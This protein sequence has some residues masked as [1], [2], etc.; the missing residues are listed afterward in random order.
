MPSELPDNAIL[1]ARSM[2]PAALLDYDRSRLRGVVLEE[3]GRVE[4]RRDRRARAGDPRGQRRAQHHRDRRAG[5]RDHRRRRHRR[6]ASAPAARRRGGLRRKGAAARAAARTSIARCATRRASPS[7]ASPIGLHMNAGLLIDMPHLDETGAESIGLFRTELQFML[8]TS[9]PRIDAQ[10]AIYR[11]GARRGRRPHRHLPHPRHRRRQDA[12]LHEAA[13][14]GEPGAGLAGDPHG[15]RPAGAAAHPVARHVA[16]RRRP[17]A[18]GDDPDGVDRRRVR[19][20]AG[21][22]RSRNRLRQAAAAASRRARSSSARWSKC[23]RCC[24]RSTRSPRPAD[25]LSVGSNDLMQYVFAAD[26]V[27]KR[28]AGR[29]DELSPA[30]LRALKAI[31]DAGAPL[32]QAGHAVRRDGRP[33]ARRDDADRARFP[34]FLDGGDGDRSDQGDGA[35]ARRRRRAARARRDARRP[36]IITARCARRC[37]R[38]PSVSPSASSAARPRPALPSIEPVMTVTAN[39]D[40]I[41]RRYEEIGAAA[42]RRRDRRR[43]LC[44]AVARARRARAAGRSDPRLARQG[45]RARRPRRAA[46]RPD[47]RSGN[48]RPRRS[49]PRAR[50]SRARADGA[51]RS[52]SRCCPRTRP[53]SATSFSKCGRG[54]AATRRLCSP[55]TCSACM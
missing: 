25:F 6:G 36:A 15:A 23:R 28:V 35:V 21:A 26:R 10:E 9:F 33:P 44:G 13:R 45:K 12:A 34:Q 50:R 43:R 41:L 18:Q 47:A 4:P 31:A 20:G 42:Q 22:V 49:R 30:F 37:R 14:R 38:S 39:F 51:R 53:T 54:P 8:A 2:S 24:G 29:F 17:R 52:A 48:A 40:I 16:R 7:T 46:R 3:A 11:S 5:R 19:R 1:V 55:A 32:R 27:N